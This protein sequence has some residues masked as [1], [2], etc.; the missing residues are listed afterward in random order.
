MC[1]SSWAH[2]Y[3]RPIPYFSLSL[4]H[5]VAATILLALRPS[6]RHRQSHRCC[7]LTVASAKPSPPDASSYSLESV[8][9]L[10]Q[11]SLAS[12]RLRRR[13]FHRRPW[14]PLCLCC[15]V[16]SQRPHLRHITPLVHVA[17]SLAP[18][19]QPCGESKPHP[20]QRVHETRSSYTKSMSSVS[21]QSDNFFLILSPLKIFADV[22]IHFSFR[23]VIPVNP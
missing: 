6:C 9:P 8:L 11:V 22:I 18:G 4:D 12:V 20:N 2:W 7:Y 3:P 16:S 5:R 1:A 21:H 13:A 15:S 14:L 10:R 23:K 17:S 19:H